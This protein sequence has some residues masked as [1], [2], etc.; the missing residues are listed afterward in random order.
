MD[1]TVIAAMSGGVDSS[2][3][4]ALLKEQG[5]NVIGITLN[6][7]QKDET[8]YSR[9]CCSATDIDDARR[10]C[11]KLS[12][13]HYVLNM[14][15]LFQKKVIDCFINDYLHGRTPNPCIACNAHVKFTAL[16]MRASEIGADYIA[17]GHYARIGYTNNGEYSL[18][19]SV[20]PKK[21]QTYVLYMLTQEKLKHILLPCGSYTKSEIRATAERY[22]LPTS[23]KTDS[24][25][26]CFIGKG[27]YA[28]F[29][30]EN[31]PAFAKQGN[32]IRSDGQILG[33][34]DGIYHFTIGQHKG[35]G[36]IS[37]EKLFVKEIDAAS[38]NV[39]VGSNDELFSSSMYVKQLSM[40][41]STPFDDG[42]VVGV[43]IRYSAREV[44]ATA[45]PAGLGKVLVRFKYPQRA[46]TPGQAAVFYSGD[47]VLGGGIIAEPLKE[48]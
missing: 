23:H 19:R 26:L 4:A 36:S 27:G 24:Q 43:K 15:E 9:S 46:V 18:M 14:R 1:K 41:T 47:T 2:V 35:L 29:I 34:H 25:D 31:C 16:L 30:R 20:D 39:I 32:I 28:G 45:E 48:T 33:K 21:D 13:P 38:G 44:E 11:A 6:V 5:Y 42:R 37:G 7:W 40:V 10:V 12:I 8:A 3:A 22:N 17:T